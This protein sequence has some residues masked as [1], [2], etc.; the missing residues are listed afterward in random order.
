MLADP[1]V[2]ALDNGATLF[3]E[4]VGL[5]FGLAL[6]LALAAGLVAIL[7]LELAAAEGVLGALEGAA[8]GLCTGRFAELLEEMADGTG[9]A[10]G[11]EEA[12]LL[13]APIT[14]AK[15]RASIA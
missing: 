7:V 5:V 12:Q 14:A 6:A 8:A 4:A 11:A 15:G 1:E 10:W 3:W 13:Q 9:S 2:A